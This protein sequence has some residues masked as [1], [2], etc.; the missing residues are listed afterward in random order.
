MPA[1]SQ[2][3]DGQHDER[4]VGDVLILLERA[5]EIIDQWG[6]CPEVG[7]RLQHVID[8]LEERG[9]SH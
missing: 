6:D 1:A 7:A 4:T 3:A 9:R 2:D 5:L 8:S